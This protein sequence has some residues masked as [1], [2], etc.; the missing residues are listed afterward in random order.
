MLEKRFAAAAVAVGPYVY[1]IGGQGG[2]GK[3]L[4]SIERFDTR[5]GQSVAF[6]AL[7]TPRLWHR[8]VVFGRKIYILGGASSVAGSAGQINMTSRRDLVRTRPGANRNAV[9]SDLVSEASFEGGQPLGL[10]RL[11]ETLDVDTAEVTTTGNMPEA[12]SEFGCVVIDDKLYVI[13][14]KRTYR[15]TRLARTNRVA[16]YDL[17]AKKW[18][19]GIPAPLATLGDA[20]VVDG[21]FVVVAGGYDGTHTSDTVFL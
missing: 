10:Q 15:K 20:T 5:T 6:A 9:A 11:I 4:S 2:T 7:K 21:P 13:G 17:S 18:S 12:R 8:A 16:I 3:I 19:E 1:V 14:G